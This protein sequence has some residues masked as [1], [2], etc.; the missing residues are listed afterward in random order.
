MI[1]CRIG[2]LKL[3][4]KRDNDLPPDLIVQLRGF[5][6]L[7]SAIRSTEKDAKQD[8]WFRFA[9]GSRAVVGKDPNA[10]ISGVKCF[11]CAGKM[12]GHRRTWA[13]VE[14]LDEKDMRQ[15][16]PASFVSP[17]SFVKPF[18]SDA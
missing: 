7:W 4:S 8:R 5:S 14:G 11:M 17:F 18:Y 2:R 3:E 1:L 10:R 12:C 15:Q 16:W 6:N 9:G 13:A